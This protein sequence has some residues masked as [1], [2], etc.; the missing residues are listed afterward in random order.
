MMAQMW[1]RLMEAD[2]DE[3]EAAGCFQALM[4]DLS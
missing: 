3:D 4:K 2:G 1:K